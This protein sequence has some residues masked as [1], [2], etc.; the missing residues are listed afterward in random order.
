[1]LV[2]IILF[3]IKYFKLSFVTHN[4]NPYK[5]SIHIQNRSNLFLRER[6]Y[7]I[8]SDGIQLSNGFSYIQIER[9]LIQKLSKPYNQCVK[10]DTS[11]YVS[12]LFQY[13]IQNNKTYLQKDCLDLCI[14]Q[15]IK[16]KCN[17]TD[18]MGEI[19]NCLDKLYA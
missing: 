17:C 7:N 16:Q 10:Q 19:N 8:E 3:K 18:E 15:L 14:D 11:E 13:F 9:D 12:K 5:M 2:L 1:M 6:I 4:I